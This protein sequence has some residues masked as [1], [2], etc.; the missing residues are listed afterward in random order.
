MFLLFTICLFYW[1]FRFLLM[2]VHSLIPPSTSSQKSQPS[3]SWV[4]LEHH[5][6]TL[7]LWTLLLAQPEVCEED[8]HG[9]TRSRPEEASRPK[10]V[11]EWS[12]ATSY[13]ENRGRRDHLLEDWSCDPARRILFLPLPW[14]IVTIHVFVLKCV[15]SFRLFL[16]DFLLYIV[17]YSMSF[18]LNVFSPLVTFSHFS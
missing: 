17:I 11:D 8:K 2:F 12:I 16:S 4:R 14:F 7:F 10:R 5:N 6:S 15:P 13:I 18:P 1:I 3:A 9:I